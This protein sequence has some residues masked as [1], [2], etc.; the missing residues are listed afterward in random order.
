MKKTITLLMTI[1]YVSLNV[2]AQKEHQTLFGD[3]K[4]SVRG[5]LGLNIKGMELNNQIG[6]LSGAEI[7]I[8]INH[9]FNVGFFGYGLLN[10][11][12]NDNVVEGERLYYEMGYGGLKLEPVIFSHNIVHLT[13]PINIGAGGV[14]LNEN[15]PWDYYNYDWES[16][17]YD[18]N[19]FVFVE[20][21]LG[22]EINL[23]KNLR[24]NASAGYLFTDRI[25][26]SGNLMQ[27]LDGW[28]GN[29]SLRLGWF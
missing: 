21:G 22:L 9:K 23:F 3:E 7:N 24:L 27:P 16:T 19:T 18:Y 11:V 6:I 14:S 25:N 5:F 1:V 12:V 10:D 8:V 2:S 20:A 13:L 4:L 15:R 26:L 17:L 28:T 29:L